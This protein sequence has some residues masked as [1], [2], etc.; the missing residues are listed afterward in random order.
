MNQLFLERQFDEAIRLIHDR[1]TEFRDLSAIE[2]LFNPFFLL[3]A[4][5]YAGDIVGAR[6]TAQQVSPGRRANCERRE[7]H[8]LVAQ[9]LQVS[10]CINTNE[11]PR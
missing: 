7:C 11:I 9:V 4:Q 2:R 8:R 5:E 6:A 10:A 1:L 3:T